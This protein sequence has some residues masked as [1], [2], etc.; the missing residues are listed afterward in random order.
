MAGAVLIQLLPQL[1]GIYA[2]AVAA[3]AL[4]AMTTVSMLPE[5]LKETGLLAGL[6][7]VLGFAFTAGLGAVG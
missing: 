4:L 5:A 2:M 6:M 3:G 7:T 1:T